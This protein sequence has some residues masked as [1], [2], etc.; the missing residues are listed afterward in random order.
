MVAKQ[1]VFPLGKPARHPYRVGA[2]KY[3]AA[4]R[5]LFVRAI[6]PFGHI[7]RM[8]TSEA[9]KR[10]GFSEPNLLLAIAALAILSDLGVPLIAKHRAYWW[11]IIMVAAAIWLAV[12]YWLGLIGSSRFS[13]PRSPKQNK[14]NK[15]GPV[16]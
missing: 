4:E 3:E 12:L 7:E 1:V 15:D 8:K 10:H 13:R 9:N 11:L 5:P 16:A 14:T 6:I 2:I